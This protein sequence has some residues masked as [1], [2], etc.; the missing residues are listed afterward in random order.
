M[1]S[2][3]IMD[4]DRASRTGLCEAVMCEGKTAELVQHALQ[5]AEAKREALDAAFQRIGRHVTAGE[6]VALA[7]QI[8]ILTEG[9]L[10]AGSRDR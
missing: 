9:N 2:P 8:R 1:S 5:L 4:W 6:A 3:I 7:R 10:H